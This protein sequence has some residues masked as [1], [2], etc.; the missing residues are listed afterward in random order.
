MGRL[1]RLE[2]RRRALVERS[3]HYRERIADELAPLARKLGAA[4]RVILALRSVLGWAAR[5]I[6]IY[7]LLRRLSRTR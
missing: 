1:R 3:A 5:I 6:P 7:T 2:Q 4:D